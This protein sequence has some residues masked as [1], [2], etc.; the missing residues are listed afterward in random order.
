MIPQAKRRGP[1]G[2]YRLKSISTMTGSWSDMRSHGSGSAIPCGQSAL[3]CHARAC[4]AAKTADDLRAVDCDLADNGVVD[5]TAAATCEV[6]NDVEC[7]LPYP[8][9][10]WLVPDPTKATG[11]RMNLPPTAI[12]P[13]I[14]DPVDPAPY[15]EVDGFA[16]TSQIIMHFPQGLDLGETMLAKMAK[17]AAKYPVDKA[18]GTNKKYTE[19]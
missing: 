2:H 9:N 13:V 18:R 11:L 5:S 8:S 19:L 10:H 12:F 7:L 15:N 6:L 14:G 4:R 1:D 3:M 16:P 17:N